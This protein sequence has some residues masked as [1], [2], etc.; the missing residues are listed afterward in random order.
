[1]TIA[2]KTPIE[3]SASLNVVDRKVLA[4]ST[5]T[6]S[7]TAD[8]MDEWIVLL[9]VHFAAHASN[10]DSDDVGRR[11]EMQV[12][13]VLQQHCPGDDV[14]GIPNEIFQKLEFLGKQFDLPAAPRYRSGY[15]IH[16][17]VADS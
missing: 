11:I 6:V 12:P 16:L 17:E 10:G 8:C 14:T 2:P 13:Y 7:D 1:M 9:V 15:E 5:D 4:R 3:I